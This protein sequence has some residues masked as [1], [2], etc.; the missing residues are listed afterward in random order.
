ML[1]LIY[2][3]GDRP[4]FSGGLLSTFALTMAGGLTLAAIS[5]YGVERPVQ[6]LGSQRRR[7]PAQASDAPTLDAAAAAPGPP[8]RGVETGTAAPAVCTSR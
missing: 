8:P 4:Q 2:L 6:L 5:Y 1:E 3:L 7:G